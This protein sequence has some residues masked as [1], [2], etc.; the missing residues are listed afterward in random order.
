MR[1]RHTCLGCLRTTS[2]DKF[3]EQMD[4]ARC[5]SAASDIWAIFGL[6]G[7]EHALYLASEENDEWRNVVICL[8]CGHYAA[9]NVRKLLSLCAGGYSTRGRQAAGAIRQGRYPVAG[10][11]HLRIA[12]PVLLNPS[13]LFS[14]YASRRKKRMRLQRLACQQV[15][16]LAGRPP[17]KRGKQSFGVRQLIVVDPISDSD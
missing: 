16:K 3:R 1:G 5:L 15:A 17:P 4:S 7:R 11:T 2:V 6:G 13:R 10:F 9:S 12:R 14:A 8:R